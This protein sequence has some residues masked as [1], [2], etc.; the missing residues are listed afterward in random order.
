MN[1]IAV[2]KCCKARVGGQNAVPYAGLTP[3][4]KAVVAGRA[5]TEFIRQCPPRR[6]RSQYPE[7]PVQNPP[8]V[9]ARHSARLVRQQRRDHAPLEIAQFVPLHD[10]APQVGKLESHLDSR[11]NLEGS[12]RSRGTGVGE[13]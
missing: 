10:Q 5:G 4:N 12:V 6:A 9:H 13:A 3:P 8:V 1:A 2:G 11:G 7:D